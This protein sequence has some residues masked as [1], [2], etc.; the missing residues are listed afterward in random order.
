MSNPVIRE[1]LDN[2][3]DKREMYTNLQENLDFESY[4]FQD[5]EPKCYALYLRCLYFQSMLLYLLHDFKQCR[6]QVLKCITFSPKDLQADEYF[7]KAQDLFASVS[8]QHNLGSENLVIFAKSCP[9]RLRDDVKEFTL[10]KQMQDS[11][12]IKSLLQQTKF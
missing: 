9:V 6:N 3:E 7:K 5:E 10:V 12:T 2:L 8:K 1:L 11:L 4:I